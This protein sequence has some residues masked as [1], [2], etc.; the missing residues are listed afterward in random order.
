M[1]LMKLILCN[2]LFLAWPV[3]AATSFQALIQAAKP[4]DTL[5]PPAGTYAGPVIIKIPITIDGHHQVTIDG[6]GKG[7]VVLIE[8]DGAQLRN[9]HLTNSGESH[10]QVDA[11]IQVRGNF[12]ILKDNRLDNCLFGIDFQQ[13]DYNIVRR[14]RITSKAFDLGL[15]GD[16]IRLWYST[17]N[18]IT[19]NHIENSRD[20]VVWYSKD[21]LIARNTAIHGRYALHF[22]YSQ[23]NQVEEND[24]QNNS[25]GIFIM[26][27]DGVSI[28]NNR[29]FHSLGTTG[30]GIGF[31]E[32]S[33]TLIENNHI[34]YCATGIYLDIS[35]FQPDTT[36][37]FTGNEV[38]YNG[39]GVLFHNDWQGNIFKNNQ[40]KGNF[41]QVAVQGAMTARRHVWQGNY[42]D[43]YL[44]FDRN[45]DG[46]GDTPYDNYAYADRLWMDVPS[47]GFFKGT[48]LL[49]LLDFLE[50]FAPLSEPVLVLQDEFPQI[51]K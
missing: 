39:I 37:Q 7:T 1:V 30:T 13:S 32:S 35:P 51:K 50:R 31:K 6:G 48:I 44:G 18:Q 41:T 40:F 36:N 34:I 25:V 12:N 22:M 47:I 24:Y 9:L 33:N 23:S 46:I 8:T 29:I 43:D 3:Q 45:Q 10:D 21:N 42:W 38:A 4:G 27:S 17:H 16:A 26:Y 20:T 14:N 28:K 19:D 49:E 11:C 2:L 15:R 5:L